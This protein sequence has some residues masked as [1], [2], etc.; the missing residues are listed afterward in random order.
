[1]LGLAEIPKFNVSST[2]EEFWTLAA[3]KTRGMSYDQFRR[4]K[5]SRIKAVNNFIS[6]CG[7]LEVESITPDNMLD[8]RHG[9]GSGSRSRV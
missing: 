2:L 3:D 4:W 7:D 5:N 9:G 1:M 6:V 8:F